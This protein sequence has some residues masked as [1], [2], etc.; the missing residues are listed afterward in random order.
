MVQTAK[1]PAPSKSTNSLCGAPIISKYPLVSAVSVTS[2][3]APWKKKIGTLE[4]VPSDDRLVHTMGTFLLSSRMGLDCLKEGEEANL[5][6][7]VLRPI[8]IYL[9][10]ARVSESPPICQ[11]SNA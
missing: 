11:C 9:K 5:G 6:A 7:C 10:V 3:C 8:Q 4:L 2:S 1:W